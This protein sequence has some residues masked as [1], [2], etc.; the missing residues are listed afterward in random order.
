MKLELEIESWKNNE[1]V[2]GVDEAGYGCFAG[3]LWVAGVCFNPFKT[4]P[5]ELK[6]LNDSKK[7]S[8][9]T[10]FQLLPAVKKYARHW[11]LIEV[12]AE[13]INNSSNVYWERFIAAENWF[14]EFTPKGARVIFDGNKALRLSEY[15]SEFLVKGDGKCLSIAAA[16]VLAKTAKDKEMKDKSSLYPQYNFDK[17]KGYFSKQHGEALQKYGMSPEHRI[18]YCQNYIR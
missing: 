17:N 14:Q 18:K 3:S 16:S 6:K 1:L 11:F 12:T 7:I 10:R 15:K 4:I 5:D 2:F 9:S 13:Q 8:E